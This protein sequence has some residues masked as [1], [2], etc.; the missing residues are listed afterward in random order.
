MIAGAYED[1]LSKHEEQ[2]RFAKRTVST[3]GA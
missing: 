3:D 2:W 1:R